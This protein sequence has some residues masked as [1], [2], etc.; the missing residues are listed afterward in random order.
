MKIKDGEYY[1]I[2]QLSRMFGIPEVTL[3]M[4]YRKDKPEY[5]LKGGVMHFT[6]E[7]ARELVRFRKR[8]KPT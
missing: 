2:P 1:S 6:S 5:V 4:R 8:G 3:R 7:V